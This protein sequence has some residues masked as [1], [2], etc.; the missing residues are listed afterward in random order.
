MTCGSLYRNIALDKRWASVRKP[1]LAHT[2]TLPPPSF[3]CRPLCN[4]IGRQ[5]HTSARQPHVEPCVFWGGV[6]GFSNVVKQEKEGTKIQQ[7]RVERQVMRGQLCQMKMP[8]QFAALQQEEI[9]FFSLLW[10]INNSQEFSQCVLT[11]ASS[12]TERGMSAI[13]RVKK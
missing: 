2:C 6:V 12:H 10:N 11:R 13:E 7:E 1:R 3:C 4:L 5:F 9:T 8:L